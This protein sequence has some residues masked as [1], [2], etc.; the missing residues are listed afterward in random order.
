MRDSRALPSFADTWLISIAS[1]ETQTVMPNRSDTIGVSRPTDAP[2]QMAGSEPVSSSPAVQQKP[3]NSNVVPA[4]S[5][6][7]DGGSIRGIGEKKSTSPATGTRSLTVRDARATAMQNQSTSLPARVDV[8]VQQPHNPSDNGWQQAAGEVA[9][10]LVVLIIGFVFRQ[11]IATALQGLTARTTKLSLGFVALE[12]AEGA[13]S[14][15]GAALNEIRE[16]ASHAPV[17][18]SS[19]ALVAS[20]SDPTPADYVVIDLGEGREWLTSRL[21]VVATLV[22]RVR[23]IHAI[24]FTVPDVLGHKFIGTASVVDLKVGL[25]RKYPWLELAYA[26]AWGLA[27][28]VS[29]HDFDPYQANAVFQDP[30]DP[31]TAIQLLRH[32]KN[33]IQ[34]RSLPAPTSSGWEL[35]GQDIWER[36]DWVT[37]SLIAELLKRGLVRSGVVRDLDASSDQF[38]RRL[39]RAEGDFVAIVEPNGVFH[40][41]VGR[42]SF[43][44]RAA[45][46]LSDER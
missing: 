12:L 42:R 38:A 41:V 32:F 10:P 45:R 19:S 11:S 9:W 7:K 43:L 13:R 18:D 24:V 15:S 5:L 28:N 34:H 20:M 31:S 36:A 46:T 39:L 8:V 35:I 23:G 30:V 27:F 37:P 29:A 6:P 2:Q 4:L 3:A 40:S 14:W 25:S 17:G 22:A 1:G 21:F 16:I 44:D 33:A 26:E